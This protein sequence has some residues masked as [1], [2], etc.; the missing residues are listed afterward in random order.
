MGPRK[1]GIEASLVRS[2]VDCPKNANTGR[3][4]FRGFCGQHPNFASGDVRKMKPDL[5]NGG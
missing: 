4:R 2:D 3:V 5:R 1:N